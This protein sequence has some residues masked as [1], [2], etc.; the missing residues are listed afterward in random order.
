MAEKTVI[1]TRIASGWF[2]VRTPFDSYDVIKNIGGFAHRN[3]DIQRTG[4]S[5]VS[6]AEFGS[7]AEC[8]QYIK[9][10]SWL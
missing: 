10:T 2:R 8:V 9:E 4:G 7:K 5:F 3:W 6:S 1:V